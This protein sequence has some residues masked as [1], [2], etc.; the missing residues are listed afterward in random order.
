VAETIPGFLPNVKQ[1]E[2]Q[3][4]KTTEEKEEEIRKMTRLNWEAY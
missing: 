3:W 1:L 4:R 2:Q